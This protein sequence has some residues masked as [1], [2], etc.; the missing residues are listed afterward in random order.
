MQFV[1]RGNAYT[2]WLSRIG[3]LDEAIDTSGIDPARNSGARYRPDIPP[4]LHQTAWCADRAIEFMEQQRSGPW[5]M[6][7]NIFDP[8]GPFDAPLSY[9]QPLP[10]QGPAARNLRRA[11]RPIRRNGCA[12]RIFQ[13]YSGAPG[14]KQRR[15]KASYYGMI[16]LIDEQVGRMLE[17]LSRTGQRDNTVV[18]FMSDHGEMLGDHGLTAKGCRFYEGAVRV[19]LV[20]SWPGRFRQGVVAD[21]LAELTDLA[22]TLAE[23]TGEPLAWTNGRSL[24][25]ILT[26]NADPAR[27]HDYVRTEYYDALNM[28]LPQ[29]P[30][31]HTPCWATMYRDE[32]HKLVNYHG[33]D[34][35]ELYHLE[36]DPLELANLW[37]AP[38]AAALRAELTQSSFDATV[39]ACDPGPA[40]IGRF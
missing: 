21:G 8:H 23:L 30:D 37:E 18:I 29:E 6:S 20:I 9:Q 1:G 35:G 34:F 25:P 26:G 13:Q 40:Q 31:R 7:V 39:A 32:R 22:P 5:L 3:R 19:P 33:L 2:D 38:A 27:H 28:Y 14:D 36:H 24:L 17:A 4:E 16:E 15:Q 10:G 12:A 11:R